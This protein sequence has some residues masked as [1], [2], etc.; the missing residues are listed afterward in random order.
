VSSDAQGGGQWFSARMRTTSRTI[1]WSFLHGKEEAM[2]AKKGRDEGG[3]VWSGNRP[4]RGAVGEGAPV[5]SNG[6]V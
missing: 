1:V 5:A 3:G 2:V 6:R 4:T